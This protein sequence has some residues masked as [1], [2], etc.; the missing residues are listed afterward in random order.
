MDILDNSF[1]PLDDDLFFEEL[2]EDENVEHKSMCAMQRL[3]DSL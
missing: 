1:L 2:D 3:E